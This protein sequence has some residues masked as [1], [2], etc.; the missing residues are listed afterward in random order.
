MGTVAPVP[1]T[2]PERSSD[3]R[4]TYTIERPDTGGW[5]TAVYLVE[6][7]GKPFNSVV[8]EQVR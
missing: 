1:D 7:P 2:T 6:V 8:F 5:H 4:A 3:A